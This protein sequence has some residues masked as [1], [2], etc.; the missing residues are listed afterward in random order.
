MDSF[1]SG[2]IPGEVCFHRHLQ[3]FAILESETFLHGDRRTIA[4]GCTIAA[5]PVPCRHGAMLALALKVLLHFSSLFFL[6]AKKGREKGCDDWTFLPDDERER[7]RRP[8]D[9]WESD[10][11]T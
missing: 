7:G 3:I 1:R 2:N 10:A 4:I 8:A 9:H 6:C 11:G 5:D